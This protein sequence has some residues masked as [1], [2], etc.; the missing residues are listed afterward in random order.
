ML[1]LKLNVLGQRIA[2]Q[3]LRRPIIQLIGQFFEAMPGNSQR[4]C[5]DQ[6]DG[7]PEQKL[8][9]RSQRDLQPT[10]PLEHLI[11]DSNHF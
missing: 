4:G 8:A 9:L 6:D 11:L 5:D 7:R 2:R 3:H 10:K 1:A